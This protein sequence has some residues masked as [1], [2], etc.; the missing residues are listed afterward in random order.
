[1]EAIEEILGCNDGDIVDETSGS[2]VVDDYFWFVA[3]IAAEERVDEVLGAGCH[4]IDGGTLETFFGKRLDVDALGDAKTSEEDE[5][6][7]HIDDDGATG[8]EDEKVVKEPKN[9]CRECIG[10]KD[11][12]EEALRFRESVVAPGEVVLLKKV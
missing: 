10:C 3:K 1:M 9:Q 11:C 5:A 7:D 6:Q 4:P 2:F 12:G 8:K